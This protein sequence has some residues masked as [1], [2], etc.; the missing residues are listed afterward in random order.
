[1]VFMRLFFCGDRCDSAI[2]KHRINRALALVFR[3]VGGRGFLRIV[4][5]CSFHFVSLH[6]SPLILLLSDHMWVPFYFNFGFLFR[7]C[8]SESDLGRRGIGLLLSGD[9]K[10]S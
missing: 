6:Y 10:E 5:L 8:D 2:T 3:G 1:M 7:Q 4:S 9:A